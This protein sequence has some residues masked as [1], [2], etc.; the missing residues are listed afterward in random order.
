MDEI[1]LPVLYTDSR[2][3]NNQHSIESLVESL[4]STFLAGWSRP[5]HQRKRVLITLRTLLE[6]ILTPGIL[7]IIS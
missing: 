4:Y 7:T 3:I 2:D 5:I 6:F 1:D